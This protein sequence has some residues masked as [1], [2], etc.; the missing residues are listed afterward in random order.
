MV[1]IRL[2]TKTNYNTFRGIKKCHNSNRQ[3]DVKLSWFPVERNALRVSKQSIVNHF[4]DQ[5]SDL[6]K[7]RRDLML[8]LILVNYLAEQTLSSFILYWNF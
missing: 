2:E 6:V 1:N 3:Y 7:Q 4:L 5:C 8:S